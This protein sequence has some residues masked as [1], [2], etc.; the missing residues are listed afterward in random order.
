MKYIKVLLCRMGSLVGA[1]GLERCSSRI[2]A[3]CDCV[4]AAK[5]AIYHQMLFGDDLF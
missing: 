3:K 2:C 1:S 4:N 5:C